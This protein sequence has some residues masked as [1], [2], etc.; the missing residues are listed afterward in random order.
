MSVV[1]G[2]HLGM[3][4]RL[5]E[6]LLVPPL[7]PVCGCR[8]E[9]GEA[10]CGA[11]ISRLRAEPPVHVSPPTGLVRVHSAFTH[12]GPARTLLN[13]FKFRSGASL[14]PLVASLILERCRS[15]PESGTLVPVPPSIEGLTTRGFDT[16]A[17]IARQLTRLRPEAGLDTAVLGRALGSRQLGRTRVER[18]GSGRRV[19]AETE[20][21][22]RV[23]LVDDV[24]TTGATLAASA[25]A[26]RLAG[27]ITVEAI[28]FS[29]RA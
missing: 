22:G 28:T 4:G 1:V 19:V 6:V 23:I 24:M 14:A 7:C 5:V 16:A 17:L 25:R 10:V 18:I 13:A 26:A 21:G 29:R 15:L 12:E 9:E 11:C 27:A 3:L 8:A 2:D 20:L